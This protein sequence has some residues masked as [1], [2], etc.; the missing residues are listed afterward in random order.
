MPT[1]PIVDL[2]ALELFQ[3]GDAQSALDAATATVRAYCGW[4][5][6]PSVTEDLTVQPVQY[7][8]QI[9]LP[10]LH[11]TDVAAVTLDGIDLVADDYR[12]TPNGVLTRVDGAYWWPYLSEPA[13]VATVTL[14]HGY[15]DAPD[16]AQVVMALATRLQSAVGGARIRQV[17]QVVY[18]NPT[19]DGEKDE[20]AVLDKYRIVPVS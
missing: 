1:D 4:H 13:Q 11:I 18:D 17:G 14:T 6:T 3:S 10:S 2:A 5:V 20:K 7:A 9:F 16:V 15:E 19:T 8:T 12:W